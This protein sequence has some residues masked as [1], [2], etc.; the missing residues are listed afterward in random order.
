[1]SKV[2]T[3]LLATTAMALSAPAFAQDAQ[4][5]SSTAAPADASAQRNEGVAD[6]VVTANR[7]ES[8][9]QKTPISMT[10]YTA[11]D[12]EKAGITSVA[13]LQKIDPSV[14][15]TSRNG[16]GYIAI[17]GIASTDVTEIGDPSV[18]VAR[19]GFFT[20]RSFS[21]ATSMYDLQ[22]V[23]I[24]KGPQGTLFGRNS[25]GGLISLITRRPGKDL[26]GNASL[27]VGN[28]GTVNAEAGVD[29]PMGKAVQLRLSGIFRRH[30]GYRQLDVIGGRGDDD[31]TLSGRATLAFQ[32]FA[33]FEGLIQ[34]QHDDVDDVGDVAYA[35]P[36]GQVF[37][38]AN[39]KRFPSY[40]PT[41][42]R[43]KG[44][45]V[46]WEFSLS[47]LPLGSTLTYAG[48]Y[49]KQNW[50]HAL[51]GS[52]SATSVA[53]F[54]QSE[55]PGTWNHEVRLATDQDS[56]FS[57][58]VGYFHFLETNQ[59]D[60]AFKELSGPFI[61]Q[62]LV[63][64]RYNIRTQSDAVFGQ[65][66]LRASST[67]RL[68]AG[69]R[70]T[71][72]KKDRTGG[73]ELRCDV[74]GIPA[75]AWPFVGCAGTPP[76]LPGSGVGAVRE[77]KPTYLGG[78]DWTPTSRNLVYGKVSTGYKSGGFNSNGSAPSVPYAAE[79]VTAYELGSKNR[80][81]NGTIVF[82]ADVFYQQYRGYQASQATPAISSGSGVFNVGSAKIYGAEAQFVV[83]SNG[84][85]FDLN[86]TYLHA[87]F[88]KNIGLITTT[89]ITTGSSVNR[90]VS[91]HD[92]PNAP[93][94]AMSAGLE[95]RIDLGGSGSLTPRIDGKYSSS[96]YFDVF[97]DN[98]TKQPAY[99]TGNVSLT[100]AA[101]GDKF[102]L[103]AFVRNFTDKTVFANAQRNFTG[104][105]FINAFEF[106]APRT[107]G[108][109]ADYRF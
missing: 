18:P 86:A 49:D 79:N 68:T 33:N 70:Y 91:G 60:A 17:R 99:A 6:I 107:F 10:V 24:L 8:S 56:A 47:D 53:T 48:G 61:N 52:G 71:W 25:T 97:N 102:Q 28:Y 43:L 73:S 84:V 4:P 83:A 89:D 59:L 66:G 54:I 35:R 11:N 96:Y 105:P 103:T 101:P 42:N 55:A 94:F 76:I 85:R 15:F 62:N 100:Y 2:V 21:I 74:A 44:D 72:D 108:I 58:Q 69:A 7:T 12:L 36:V 78:I 63:H 65:F 92:L 37:G 82:N 38:N 26:G 98:D 32:P 13:N 93:S 34:Y 57:A 31:H 23:E 27:E 106:Q 75:F 64:F 88:D 90:N 51:D 50:N 67:I 104:T 45:R 80:F 22:R 30:D 9:V 87:R 109:R 95:Y 16:A 39:S 46:R 29:L 5:K 3:I 19:D 41:H 14:N 81:A 40:A 20:N 1:M 77:S